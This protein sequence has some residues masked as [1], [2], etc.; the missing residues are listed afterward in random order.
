MCSQP[1][2]PFRPPGIRELPELPEIPDLPSQ[3]QSSGFS[4]RPARPARFTAFSES[5]I[6][7]GRT[8]INRVKASAP[9][10]LL[11]DANL[12]TGRILD[13]G[14][15]RGADTRWLAQQGLDVTGWDPNHASDTECTSDYDTIVCN[16]VL[17]V[18]PTEME[19]RELAA[20]KAQLAPNGLAYIAVRG[21]VEAF[22][23]TGRIVGAGTFQRA[24]YLQIPLVYERKGRFRIY[25]MEAS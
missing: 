13:Y 15:G 23:V 6:R 1:F 16:Y 10:C 9:T 22:G 21:D 8:A 20:I 17:N 18:L 25:R 4:A 11:F 2:D 14:C 24:V 7:G 12:L 5:T 3:L 19:T